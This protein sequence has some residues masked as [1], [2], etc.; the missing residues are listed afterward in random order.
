M[1]ALIAAAPAFG[2]CKSGCGTPAA[3]T[4]ISI[5]RAD[6]PITIDGKCGERSW[7]HAFR[8]PA[9]EDADG[10]INPHA[11]LRATADEENLYFEVYVG[12]IDIESNGD[13]V[14]LDVGPVH[15]ELRPK[16]ASAPAGVRTAVDCDDTIDDPKHMDEEWVNEVAIPW[17]LLGTHEVSVRAAR[18]DVGA[19]Q[20][21]HAMAWPRN[22]PA[23]LRFDPTAAAPVL[24]AG[25]PGSRPR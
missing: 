19:N 23:L 14:N 22:A 12:D 11:E 25:A 18:V 4:A 20:A 24:P 10:G 3:S 6:G 1:L 2:A 7:Q 21:P 16:S 9:F 17:S 8:S 13:V 5:P 15:I